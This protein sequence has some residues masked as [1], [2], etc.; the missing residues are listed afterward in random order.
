MRVVLEEQVRAWSRALGGGGGAPAGMS[1]LLDLNLPCNLRCQGCDGVGPAAL[2]GASVRLLSHDVVRRAVESGA[3]RVDVAFFGGE[4]L[5]ERASLLALS[6]DVKRACERLHIDYAGH[7]V[8][9]GTLLATVDPGALARAG[10][11]SIQVTLEGGPRPHDRVRRTSDGGGTWERIVAGLRRMRGAAQVVVRSSAG[12]DQEIAELVGA[13]DREGVLAGG[14]VAALL[15]ARRAPYVE[16]A[17][18]LVHLFPLLAAW[19]CLVQ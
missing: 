16:Q 9:N 18:D 4:P 2:P 7:L 6:A 1:C 13:L 17:R 15:L 11:R 3:S 10:L 14:G 19:P 12:D 8:T 5:L